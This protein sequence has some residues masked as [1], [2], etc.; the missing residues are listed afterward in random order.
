MGLD[1]IIYCCSDEFDKLIEKSKGY[2]Y[3]IPEKIELIDTQAV[4]NS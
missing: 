2:K 1:D 4:I 3:I